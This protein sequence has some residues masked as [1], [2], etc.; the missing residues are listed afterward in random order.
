MAKKF[1]KDAVLATGN[2][3]GEGESLL[4]PAEI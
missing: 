4:C 1:E 2:A 3:E